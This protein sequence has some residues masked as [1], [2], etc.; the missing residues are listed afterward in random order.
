MYFMSFTSQIMLATYSF[1]V[2]CTIV[3]Y[4]FISVSFLLEIQ[5][6]YAITNEKINIEGIIHLKL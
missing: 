1:V 3:T 4:E 6:V 5:I 2:I